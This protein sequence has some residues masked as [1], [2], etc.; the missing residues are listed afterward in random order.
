M[1]KYYAPNAL[2]AAAKIAAKSPS[3]EGYAATASFTYHN[4]DG[5]ALYHQ[6]RFDNASLGKKEFR[7]LTEAA[8]GCFVITAPARPR[9]LYRLPQLLSAN[10]S[11]PVYLVEGEKCADALAALGLI[12][13]TSPNGC[14]GV[15]AADWTPLRGRQVV[16]WPDN[17]TAGETYQRAVIARLTEIEGEG[18]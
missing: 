13:T 7:P 6:V 1:S 4:A 15:S 3:L 12:A 17:D 18:A 2:A 14:Q 10:R 5:S 9:P 11:L 16:L 8:P